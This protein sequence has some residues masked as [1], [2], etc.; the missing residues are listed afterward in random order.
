LLRGTHPWL[1]NGCSGT[2][3]PAA[4]FVGRRSWRRGQTAG[5][6]SIPRWSTDKPQVVTRRKAKGGGKKKNNGCSGTLHH[7]GPTA[8]WTHEG[9]FG[10]NCSIS[11]RTHS[12][13]VE[14]DQRPVHYLPETT[15][16]QH[17]TER[18][19]L[20]RRLRRK[21]PD[22]DQAAFQAKCNELRLLAAGTERANPAFFAIRNS[23]NDTLRADKQHYLEYTTRSQ[24]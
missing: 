3:V 8:H 6:G 5:G 23:W 24:T 17:V 7:D 16:R 19:F 11:N 4:Q 13:N 9:Q 10:S 20:D 18:A 14:A 21:A 22:T 2:G 1:H 12:R 15:L